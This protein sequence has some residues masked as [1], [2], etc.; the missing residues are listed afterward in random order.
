MNHLRLSR[1]APLSGLAAAVLIVAGIFLV[2]SGRYPPPNEVEIAAMTGSESSTPV[3]RYVGALSVFLLIWFA[4]SLRSALRQH[5]EEPGR[6]SAVAF[7]GGIVTGAVLAVAFA[8]SPSGISPSGAAA[9][10]SLRSQLLGEALPLG[11][12]ILVGAAGVVSLR[13]A[14]FPAWF[15][16]FSVL[17]ALASLSPYGFYGQVAAMLWIVIVS[18]W[19]FVRETSSTPA[20]TRQ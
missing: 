5:E 17:A 13:S 14:A 15:G 12:A 11:L 6:L 9:L 20:V 19:L 18:I 8:I 7:A 4:G 10:Y 16:W 1:F 2:G 3:G